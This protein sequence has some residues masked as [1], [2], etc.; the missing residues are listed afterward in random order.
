M[1]NRALTLTAAVFGLLA[2]ALLL[3]RADLA[4]MALPF[5][6]YLGWG[7]LRAPAAEKVRGGLRAVRKVEALRA[8]GKTRITVRVEVE[9]RGPALERLH[10]SDEPQNGIRPENGRLAQATEL[11]AGETATLEYSFTAARGTFIWKTVRAVAGDSFGLTGE[12]LALDAPAEVLASPAL[13]KF[14]PFPLRTQR[15]LA[16]SGSI[17]ARRGGSGT[18]FWGVREYHP[19]DPLRHL[20]WRLNARHPQLLFTKE[21]EQESIA[22]IGLILDARLKT[23]AVRGGESLFE[24]SA[25]AAASLAEVFLR[26]GN[27]V[28]LFVTGDPPVSLYPGYGKVQLN[29]ILHALARSGTHSGGTLGDIRLFP[30]QIFSSRSLILVISPLAAND[31]RLFPRLRA[32][33]YQVL[34]ISPDPLDYARAELPADRT[35]RLA[36]RLAR[37][38]RQLE[39]FRI[40]KLWIP[41]IDWTVGRPLA[42]LVRQALSRTRVQVNRG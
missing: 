11:R 9:N 39:I 40:R 12:A 42:P 34:L 29:R 24:H 3:R 2:A 38:E 4:W 7:L 36:N 17:P 8:D 27:R 20:D 25:R 6:T 23:D 18:D 41:V 33:G 26:Q 22:D 15:T 14:R 28:S 37:M 19:G 13:Q 5:L 16:S 35:G 10:L 21:F 1:N 32:H 30:V 31:W